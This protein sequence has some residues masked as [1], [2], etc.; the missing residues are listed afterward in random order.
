MLLRDILPTLE[1]LAPLRHA[2]SWDNVGLLAG[3]PAAAVERVLLTIDY[4][5]AVAAE[6]RRLGAQLV[7][8]Y[9]P[10]LF[11]AV[12]RLDAK[13]LIFQAI[14]DGIALYSPHTA[15]DVAEGGTND[16]LADA[17]GLATRGPLQ[18]AASKDA[19]YK[20]ITFVPEAE[21]ERVAAALFAAGAGRIGKYSA[22]SFRTPGTGTF[23]GEEG[24][25]P[26]VGSAGRLESVSEL[27]LETVLP[28][29]RVEAVIAALRGACSYEEPAFDL[30]RLAPPPDGVAS[31]ASAS[32]PPRDRA[33]RSSP[34]SS[35]RSASRPC[36]WPGP[37]RAMSAAPPCARARAAAC[38][39]R[40]SPSGPSSSSPASSLTTTPCAPP[41]WG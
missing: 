14:R 16:L 37:W 41:R 19:Q 25:Q 11:Q 5:P 2:E 29:E 39:R 28:I 8:A 40:P 15:L 32:S 26:A 1:A 31:A 7:V 18:R 9:H 12:K 21:I 4:T 3:D 27:R 17:L 22:C 23:F 36:W 24:A 33:P 13:S 34:R 20:L 30:V 35:G 10:P 38:S 6:A